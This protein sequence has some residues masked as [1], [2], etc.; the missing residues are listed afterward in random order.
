VVHRAWPAAPAAG[1][2][3]ESAGAADLTDDQAG[4]VELAQLVLEATG[5][6]PGASLEDDVTA[7]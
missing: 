3:E 4:A 2:G 1:L 5:Q 6:D 7:C